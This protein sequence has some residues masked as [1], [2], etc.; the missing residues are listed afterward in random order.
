MRTLRILF[1][2][3]A[4]GTASI[5][6]LAGS[7]PAAHA[8]DVDVHVYRPY[9]APRAVY[10]GPRRVVTVGPHCVTRRT[11][12]WTGYRFVYRTVRRCY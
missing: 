6:G 8:G 1:A 5:A 12:I 2:A 11:R 4:A 9:Y 10:V 3:T 7:P